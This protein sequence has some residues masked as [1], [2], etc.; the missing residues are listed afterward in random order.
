M[1]MDEM[2]DMRAIVGSHDIVLLSLDTL[3]FDAAQRCFERGEL[4]CLSRHLPAS[5]WERRHT[6]GSFTYAAHAAF[7]AGFLP[8][9]ATPGPHP[10][11]FALEFDGS[12]TTV[13]GTYVVRGRADIVGGLADAGYHTLCIGGVGFFNLRNALGRQLPGL[14]AERHW[15]PTF[16]V[17]SRDS[18]EQQVS[19]ACGRLADADLHQRRCFL[20]INV[21]AL[22]QPNHH[23]LPGADNDSFD[24]HCAALR[25]VDGALAPLFGALR[26]RGPAFVI[27]CSDHGTAYGEDGYH[28]HRLAHE[29]VMTVPYAHFA[30]ES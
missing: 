28:G 15:T 23:Y 5:G 1:R 16:G 6:P 2:P 25:Y 17:T 22:H 13:D 4:P 26:R 3:R 30:I 27:V 7:F 24:T 12:E 14:F 10:R 21:S 8:T 20:F 19:L 9:P 18:T 29:V 11:L